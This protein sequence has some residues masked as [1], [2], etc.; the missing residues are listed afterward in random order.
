[1]TTNST[2]PDVDQAQRFM[3]RILGNDEGSLFLGW[4]EE[5]P[6]TPKSS[7]KSKTFQWPSEREQAIEWIEKTSQQYPVYWCPILGSTP[8]RS[9]GSGVSHRWLW[10]DI[11]GAPG[12]RAVIDTLRPRVVN[13]G[14]PGHTH[15]YVPLSDDLNVD[16]YH[17]LRRGLRDAVGGAADAKIAD[18][19]LMRLPGTLN[20]RTDPPTLVTVEPGPAKRWTYDRLLASVTGELDRV[21]VD[22][23]DDDVDV[24]AVNWDRLK[25]R[26]RN[27]VRAA[28][29][30]D[31][32]GEG[33]ER[34][35]RH[36][37]VVLACRDAGMTLAET[38]VVCQHY[39]PSVE[40]FGWRDGGVAK[41][42][43]DS[44]A[45]PKKAEGSATVTDR[46]ADPDDSGRRLIVEQVDPSDI[47]RLEWLWNKR[48]PAGMFSLVGGV[49]DTGKSTLC[50]DLVTKVTRGELEGEF[51]G[52]PSG[53][54]Y[55]ATEDSWR[56]TLNPRLTAAGA[57]FRYVHRVRVKDKGEESWLT[58]PG[59]LDAL[60]KGAIDNG[61]KLIVLDPVESVIDGKVD[62][63]SSPKLRAALE[64]IKR[65]AEQAHC[66][67]L[68]IKHFNKEQNTTDIGLLMSGLRTWSAVARSSMGTFKH[69][70]HDDQFVMKMGKNNLAM[71]QPDLGFKFISV[72]VPI[73]GEDDADV[74]RLEWL[75]ESDVDFDQLSK[76]AEQVTSPTGNWLKEQ[77]RDGPVSRAEIIARGEVEDYAVSTLDKQ[78]KKLGGKMNDKTFGGGA[79]WSI[80]GFSRADATRD[81]RQHGN[82]GKD[83]NVDDGD[84]DP[85]IVNIIKIAVLPGS[86]MP[87][88][89]RK[90]PLTLVRGAEPRDIDFTHVDRRRRRKSAGRR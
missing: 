26:L 52:Q 78:Y 66:T 1:M 34:Y 27:S 44:W 77:L 55:V 17:A 48:I 68:G 50:L 43:R 80:P 38:I 15:L 63:L 76:N 73:P 3:S 22:G 2:Q 82:I 4:K 58:I 90:T 18:N 89:A 36:H 28:L 39:E 42:V 54:I 10:V 56:Y 65:M 20:F 74:A 8:K 70:Q 83:G 6:T 30:R 41:A 25:R 9:R 14:R 59:D 47:G 12:D 32:C 61:I 31:E 86:H 67:V 5:S 75:G 53:V 81:G 45:A 35:R 72:A 16:D 33:T 37:A 24:A 87:A 49:E 51:Y 88:P 19:D 23:S 57:D 13:S 7:M 11:D 69:P 46:K 79:M 21:G 71:K 60:A 29:A 64:P 84:T 85:N 62:H 40:K